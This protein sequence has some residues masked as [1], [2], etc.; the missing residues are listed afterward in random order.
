VVATDRVV[1]VTAG[2]CGVGREIARDLAGRGY[3]V[4]LAYLGDHTAAEST[5]E[6]ILATNGVAVSV[7][8]DLCDEVDV[9][10]LFAEAAHAYGGVDVAVHAAEPR[11]ALVVSREACRRLREGGAIVLLS[12]STDAASADAVEALVPRLAREL[13]GQDVTVNAVTYRQEDGSARAVADVVAVLVGDRGR[14][15]SG[16]I[17]RLDEPGL[18]P[19]SVPG[20]RNRLSREVREDRPPE[21]N[22]STI[23]AGTEGA[24]TAPEAGTLDLR[25][26]VVVLPVTDVDRAKDFYT[27]ALR[28]RLDAD[29]TAPDGLRV[30]QVTPPGSRCSIIFG[31]ALTSAAP[32]STQGL[33]FVVENIERAQAELVA[34]GVEMSDVFHDVGGV[35]HH[36]GTEG[37]LPGPD[38]ERRS[39]SSFASFSD[40]DGNGWL[41]QEIT[42]RLPGR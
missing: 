21:V 2:S 24:T 7:R 10:R 8:A 36:A 37:R 34:S 20:A 26:E 40:P 9:E 6:E 35:F 25:L 42:T 41:L 15:I 32:G 17:I 5:V 12:R 39:Y 30:V 29:F 13:E 14:T 28:C 38:P 22:M 31:A 33:I 18:P 27:R 3:A 16:G 1:I 19:G 23:D 4:A 11:G